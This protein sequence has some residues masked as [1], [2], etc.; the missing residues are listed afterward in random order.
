MNKL[1]DIEVSLSQ[2]Q[3]YGTKHFIVLCLAFVSSSLLII[4]AIVS[5]VLSCI[6]WDIFIVLVC[7]ICIIIGVGFLSVSIYCFVKDRKIK[8]R[9]VI[10]L[11]DAVKTSALSSK[12]DEFRAG[13]QPLSVKIQVQFSLNGVTYVRDSRA[14]CVGGQRG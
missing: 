2:G 8:R 7:I 1:S 12:V 5:L 3:L 14:T 11:E 9:V 4:V 10:W 6:E 13:L